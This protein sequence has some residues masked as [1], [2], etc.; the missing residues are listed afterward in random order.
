MKILALDPGSVYTGFAVG[1]D[2]Q[3][4]HSGVI[5]LQTRGRSKRRTIWARCALLYSQLSALID[6][7][8]P[9]VVGVEWPMG[10]GGN[11]AKIKLGMVLGVIATCAGQ[12][13]LPVFEVNP[14]EVK[15]T[16]CHKGA[17]AYAGAFAG[18][19]V[20]KDEAD[21]I[22]VFLALYSKIRHISIQEALDT[23]GDSWSTR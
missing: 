12:R 13:D 7:V 1:Y 9:D 11:A 19:K 5:V 6:D 15:Q 22:G 20:R 17:L 14:T 23:W 10:P 21:A 16:G 3:Y 2:G 18:R 8:A 4:V